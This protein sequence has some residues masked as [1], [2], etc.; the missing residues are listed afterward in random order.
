MAAFITY[1]KLWI[2]LKK[3][4]LHL[5]F[6]MCLLTYK[7]HHDKV[8][9]RSRS[10][11]ALWV[12]AGL[13]GGRAGWRVRRLHLY[14]QTHTHTENI[15]TSDNTIIRGFCRVT[16]WGVIC[17]YHGIILLR[18]KASRCKRGEGQIQTG[19]CYL[20]THPHTD[21][22]KNTRPQM[23]HKQRTVSPT[24]ARRNKF[25]CVYFTCVLGLFTKAPIF[26]VNA[27]SVST[28]SDSEPLLL[29]SSLLASPLCD[30]PSSLPLQQAETGSFVTS[31]FYSW[32]TNPK[33]PPLWL[34]PN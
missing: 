34:S 16:S 28:G 14:T 31:R 4:F 2:A 33:L 7:V 24:P 26:L 10:L 22:A 18:V 30:R 23:M 27:L 11:R 6:A 12:E 9:V 32:D 21:L 5:C 3:T 17:H 20:N 29:P 8:V 1:I 19:C 25:L 15:L 13:K